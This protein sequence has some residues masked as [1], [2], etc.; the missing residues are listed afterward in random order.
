MSS[1]ELKIR[2]K[3]AYFSQNRAV[4]KE[5]YISLCY[6]LPSNFG[7]VKRATLMR[8]ETSFNGKNLNL[9]VISE[10]SVGRLVSTNDII[11]QNLKTWIGQYKMIGDTIDILDARIINLKINF[12]VVGFNNIGKFDVLSDCIATLSNYYVSNY[13]DIGEPFKI[14]DV[15]KILNG[16]PSVVD[17]KMVEVVPIQNTGYS[18]FQIALEDLISD[19]GRYLI[20]PENAVF[21]IK[22]PLTDIIGEIV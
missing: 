21:E 7:Q 2:A 16:V 13:Y 4:T 10:D 6:N 19:D 1:E 18:S 11:K 5:D 15:Y 9:Y 12:S 8:D 3:G 22:F 20:P 17:T 14:S